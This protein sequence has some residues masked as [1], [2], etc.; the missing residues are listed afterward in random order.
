VKE[1]LMGMP[2]TRDAV[3]L[4]YPTMARLAE[5]RKLTDKET[6]YRV[7][8]PGGRELGHVPGQF[9]MVSLFGVG[10][11]PI[12][13]SSSPTR[14]GYF[15]LVV[16]RVGMLTEVLSR[17]EA[18]ATVGIR[19]PFG[20]GFDTERLRGKDIVIRGGG[21][22]IVPLRSMIQY[23]LDRR[24]EFGRLVILYGARSPQEL[25][26]E[27]ERAEWACR[28]D[29]EFHLTVDNGDAGWTGKVGVITTLVPPLSLDVEKTAVLVCGPP[30]MY[31]FALLSLQGKQVRDDQVFLSLERR[32]KCGVGKCGHC[33]INDLYVCRCGPVFSYAEV[34]D[35]KEAV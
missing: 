28:R 2:E 26:F 11:A 19:G 1:G 20:R 10:E 12:S 7:E 21:I 27:E 5:V 16:R 29:C 23:V 4:Y 24:Q 30:V 33:Q 35:R 3:D 13:I 32:M 31:K 22:G 18:G 14:K 15:D 34:K 25:L 17:F 6:F 8:L 9:V